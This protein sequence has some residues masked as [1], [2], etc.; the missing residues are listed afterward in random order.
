MS[1][2][3]EILSRKINT[4]A[5]IVASSNPR[6]RERVRREMT[7]VPQFQCIIPPN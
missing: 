6:A 1:E 7:Y 5:E 4:L 3:F 2:E